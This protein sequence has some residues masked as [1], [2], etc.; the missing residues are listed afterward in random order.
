MIRGLVIGKFM[1]LHNGHIALI[2]YAADHC[3]EVIVSMSFTDSDSI[4]PQLRFGWIEET[5]KDNPKI[6]PR[7]VED[8]FDREDL[9]WNER[10]VIWADFIKKKYANI[11]VIISSEDYGSML[12]AQLGIK[13]LSFD[14]ERKKYPVSG[15]KIR[16]QPFQYWHFIPTVV[17]PY[18]VK[19][20]CFYGP[21]S[22]GKSTMAEHIAR[23][24][25]TEFVPE[26]SKEIVTT[27]DFTIDDIIK[28]GYAQTERV[29]AKT[30]TANKILI[31]DTDVITTEIYCQ[32]YLKTIPPILFE[33]EKMV[34]YHLYFLFV[35]D[36][37]W[38]AD[39]IRDL[40]E[41]EKRKEMFEIF[42]NEL[43][44]RSIQYILVKGNWE[45]RQ[46]IIRRRIA[47]LVDD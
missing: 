7:L 35:P 2:K 24:Y 38:V 45:E 25:E 15:S 3:D 39:G 17:R 8:D 14:P 30:K 11:N 47:K 37:P 18:F 21:E 32:H 34:T 20:I 31:C 42:K 33:L 22:T 36:V 9:P 12:A 40:G 46:N 13:H 19:K 29:L 41:D 26:V 16:Q 27:N 4:N 10:I 5:F 43:G 6:L 23:Y 28:I 44:R 1:P